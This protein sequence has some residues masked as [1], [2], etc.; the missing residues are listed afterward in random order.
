MSN[1]FS[2]G[3]GVRSSEWVIGETQRSVRIARGNVKTHPAGG[4]KKGLRPITIGVASRVRR[5]CNGCGLA[6]LQALP[7]LFLHVGPI[8]RS[9]NRAGKLRRHR[10]KSLRS[11][12]QVQALE[13][14]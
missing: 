12:E 1:P 5:R 6:W 2:S 10:D 7:F 8:I 3:M 14:W 13:A 11:T 9:T 4:A